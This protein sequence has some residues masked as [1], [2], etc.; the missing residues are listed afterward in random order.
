MRTCP[1]L[2]SGKMRDVDPS[3]LWHLRLVSRRLN[4]VATP[5][6]YRVLRMN[7]ALLDLDAEQRYPHVFDH[8]SAFTS[9]VIVR[10]DLEPAGIRRVLARVDRLSKIQ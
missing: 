6:A 10:S 1:G 8:I 5:I 4:A 9:Q 2:T 3:S 7:E